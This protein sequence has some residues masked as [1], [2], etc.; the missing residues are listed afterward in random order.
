MMKKQ[1]YK[2]R[3][4]WLLS[5]FG[6]LSICGVIL[7]NLNF[8]AGGILLIIFSFVFLMAFIISLTKKKD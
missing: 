4:V 6:L 1:D 8:K 3:D 2:N 7:I 5:I